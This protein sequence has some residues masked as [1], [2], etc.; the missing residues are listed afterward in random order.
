MGIKNRKKT[1]DE[2][3]LDLKSKGKWDDNYDYSKV[4]YDENRTNN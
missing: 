3:L 1:T 4:K 2:F